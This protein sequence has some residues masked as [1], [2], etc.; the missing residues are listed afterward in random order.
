[1]P[2][3]LIVILIAALFVGGVVFLLA[4]SG[5]TVRKGEASEAQEV[6]DTRAVRRRLEEQ[7]ERDL[8]NEDDLRR[9]DGRS[10]D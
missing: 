5:R 6:S 4:Y 10:S 7:A 8:G 9:S 2:L 1:M 3:V